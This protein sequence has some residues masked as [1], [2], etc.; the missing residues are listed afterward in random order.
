MQIDRGL[1]SFYSHMSIYNIY[2]ILAY[3]KA[4]KTE[5]E[6]F[7]VFILPHGRRPSSFG[8]ELA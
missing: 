1:S 4:F 7:L 3:K 6:A 8:L 5:P 2:G